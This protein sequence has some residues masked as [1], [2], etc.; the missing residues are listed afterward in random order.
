M[1]IVSDDCD[2]V[3]CDYEMESGCFYGAFAGRGQVGM[4]GDGVFPGVVS[5]SEGESV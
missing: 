2:R 3:A 5:H 1:A 4:E